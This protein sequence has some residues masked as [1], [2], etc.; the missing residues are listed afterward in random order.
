RTLAGIEYA[1][2]VCNSGDF[3]DTDCSGSS[4]LSPDN[5]IS[6]QSCK[7]NNADDCTGEIC[8][9]NYCIYE[10]T[11][12]ENGAM[13]VQRSCSI[14][15]FAHFPDGSRT[16]L[17]NQNQC[18]KKIINGIETSFEICNTGDFCDTHC[19]GSTS[20]SILLSLLLLPVT[21]LIK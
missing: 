21:Y 15:N 2:E 10:R 18:E 8:Q 16:T 14:P 19:N 4:S 20:L 9:G 13:S 3:C 5:M 17:Y 7:A 12:Q 11:K 6:C 1:Y